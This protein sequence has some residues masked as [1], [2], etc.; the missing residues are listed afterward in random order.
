[1]ECFAATIDILFRGGEKGPQRK[2]KDPRNDAPEAIR[3]VSLALVMWEG[4]N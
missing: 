4:T 2:N 3:H 1:M